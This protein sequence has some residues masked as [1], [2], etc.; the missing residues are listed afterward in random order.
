MALL[1]LQRRSIAAG[2]G[3]WG[4]ERA[5]QALKQL[6]WGRHKCPWMLPNVDRCGLLEWFGG[7]GKS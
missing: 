5:G 2:G 7:S 3:G 1:V 6:V 4:A